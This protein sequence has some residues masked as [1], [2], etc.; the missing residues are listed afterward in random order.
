MLPKTLTEYST[1]LLSFLINKIL[2][3]KPP[4]P[5]VKKI[6]IIKLDHIGDVL[7]A[8]PVITNLK[9]CYPQAHIAMLVGSWSKSII[10][11]NPYLDEIFCYDAPFFCRN[12]K[13][14]SFKGAV[15]LLIRLRREQFDLLVEL[16]GNLLTLILAASKGGKCRLDRATQ[17]IES[18]LFNLTLSEHE[19][20]INLDALRYA[21]TPVKSHRTLFCV[22][23]ECQI[24]AKTFLKEISI[25]ES[26]PIIAIHPTSPV[27]IKRWPL[28]RFAELADI[29]IKKFD[30]QI[31]FLGLA[32]EGEIIAE[33][34]SLMKVKSFNIAGRTNLQQLAGVL[35]SCQLYIGNDSGPMH[36]AAT[37]GMPV[38]G[39][40]GPSSPQRFGPHGSN[41]IAIRK[42]DCPP[43]MKESC[44]LGGGG[45][46]T[47][48]TVEDVIS[49]LPRS[50]DNIAQATSCKAS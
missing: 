23:Q 7:L 40:F 14:A 38:I 30:A 11:S 8:T 28:E 31:L 49:F 10:E 42:T 36:L 44:K 5:D 20:E 4:A 13:P 39:L 34:Q 50:F 32:S 29:L 46:I 1:L 47:E 25:L 3:R 19:V 35:Q 6:L 45:C 9:L 48:I 43:C 18:K 2:Y 33:I 24:W 26:K 37:V 15:K 21:N 17:R 12:G 41:C 27:L 16:R 22:P